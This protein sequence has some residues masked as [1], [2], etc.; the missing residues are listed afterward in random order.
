MITIL[1][2]DDDHYLCEELADRIAAMGHQ[3]ISVHCVEHALA[4]L[5]K[6]DTAIDLI[7]LDLGIPVKPEGP[8]R[9]ETGINLLGRIRSKPGAPPIIVITS[10]GMGDYYL[11]LKVMQMGARGFIGKPF[12]KE[13][14]EDQINKILGDAKPDHFLPDGR[15]RPFEGGVF[16]VHESHFELVGVEIGGIR[17]PSIIRRVISVLAQK[18]KLPGIRMSAEYLSKATGHDAQGITA[19]ISDFRNQS[20]DK[21]RAKGWECGK[22]DIIET[23]LGG[24]YQF[25]EWITVREG[26]QNLTRSQV[27]TDADL[28]VSKFAG[29]P[30][31]T[32]RQ[33]DEAVEISGL[34]VGVALA[35]LTES[36]RLRKVNGSGSSTTYEVIPAP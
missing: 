15:L 31:L 5:E 27:A 4:T 18:P 14:P 23:P 10:H 32:R 29:K 28:V 11:C 26:Y 21:M 16:I 8:T 34:R 17:S 25:K 24:G 12:D 33:I 13:P 30:R 22:Q 3:S 2:I 7:L 36:K 6:I 9:P 35:R 1:I 19:A 20:V